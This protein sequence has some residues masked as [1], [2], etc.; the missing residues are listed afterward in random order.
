MKID[1]KT[2]YNV[3]VVLVIIL[4]GLN[5]LHARRYNSLEQEYRKHKDY[6]IDTVYKRGFYD[7]KN[8]CDSLNILNK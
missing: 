7:G 4:S 6:L 8:Y 1:L 3:L 2:K 5:L